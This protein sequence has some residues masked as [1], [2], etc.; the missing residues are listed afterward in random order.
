MKMFGKMDSP[1][2]SVLIDTDA[3]G[4]PYFLGIYVNVNIW[5]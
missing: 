1:S 4:K 2:I 3:C 5:G